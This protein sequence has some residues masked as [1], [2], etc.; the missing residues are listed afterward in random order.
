MAINNL[1]AKKYAIAAFNVAKKANIVDQFSADLKNF[2]SSLP[3][4]I[5]KE[6][7]NPAISKA[8]LKDII[9]AF[10]DKMSL[11][12]EVVSFLEIVAQERRISNIVAIENHFAK[13]VKNEKNILEVEVFAAKSLD[14]KEIEEIKSIL[15]KKY[16]NNSIEIK[17]SIKKDI[18]G[19]IQI[20]IESMMI[21]ASL[22]RQL[23]ALN[24]QFQSIL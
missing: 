12:G 17:Q 2:V 18:L 10:G 13:L 8:S 9:I 14:D 23:S 21:D 1:L 4:S 11:A 24:Q 6:L 20:K 19:G 15:V 7:S 16:V 3:K 22:K 5:I